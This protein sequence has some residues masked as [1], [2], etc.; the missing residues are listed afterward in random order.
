MGLSALAFAQRRAPSI[1]LVGGV[2]ERHRD[3]HRDRYNYSRRPPD[4]SILPVE[5][6][7]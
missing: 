5:M 1:P 3:F 4:R 6:T 2:A 7:L